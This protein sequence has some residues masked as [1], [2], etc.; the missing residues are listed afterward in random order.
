MLSDWSCSNSN[1]LITYKGNHLIRLGQANALMH[2]KSKK[3]KLR[4]LKCHIRKD[5]WR[6]Y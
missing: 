1:L 5:S 2:K 3:R 6:I 4:L